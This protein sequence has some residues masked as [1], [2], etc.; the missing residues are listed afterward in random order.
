MAAVLAYGPGAV[1]SHR[2]AA[3]PHGLRAD[4]RTR[5][6]V[7]VPSKSVCQRRGLQAH[8][9]AALTQADV[10]AIDGIPATTLAR[11][12]I[13]LAE[14]VGRRAV[15][16]AMDAAERR[17]VFDLR[18]VDAALA[19]TDGRAGAAVIRSILHEYHGPAER[20]PFVEAFLS[21][22][23]RI[24]L[25]EPEPEALIMLRTAPSTWTSSGG[26]SGSPSSSTAAGSTTP[27]AGSTRP[28]TATSSYS[29]RAS[30]R[31]GSPGGSF[32]PSPPALDGA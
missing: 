17:R 20:Q 6:D 31:F 1:L 25:P 7:S 4:N 27:R 13:D 21:L 32:T 12:F 22:I 9:A 14:V 15:T 23:E 29:W 2:A 5:I 19:R 3:A 10:T 8:A 26:R 30:S 24:G 16:N 28:A 18:E 11:T